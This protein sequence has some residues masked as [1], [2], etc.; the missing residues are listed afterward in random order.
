[1]HFTRVRRVPRLRGAPREG[2]VSVSLA[3]VRVRV[4][5]TR[6][7]VLEVGVIGTGC[8]QLGGL[9]LAGK[10]INQSVGPT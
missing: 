8:Q 4:F 9:G 6:V 10:G 1:M 5:G 7:R 2:R 3:W